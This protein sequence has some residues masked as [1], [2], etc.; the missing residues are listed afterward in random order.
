MAKRSP[1]KVLLFLILLLVVAYLCKRGW[2][3]FYATSLPSDMPP[4]M[5]S[6]V[7][8]GDY[9]YVHNT[10]PGAVSQPG[11]F[12]MGDESRA[13]VANTPTPS[14]AQ[15]KAAPQDDKT[16]ISMFQ[17]DWGV[18]S[19]S[20][21]WY[22]YNGRTVYGRYVGVN[23]W[24]SISYVVKPPPPPAAPAPVSTGVYCIGEVGS[25]GDAWATRHYAG[26]HWIR[27]APPVGNGVYWIWGVSNSGNEARP[28]NEAF[29]F[30]HS[31]NNTTGSNIQA[32]MYGGADNYAT[33][34]I[35]GEQL[36]RFDGSL[37]SPYENVTLRPGANNIQIF[38]QNGSASPAAVWL[39][40]KD[41][42]GRILVKSDCTNWSTSP[43]AAAAPAA[44]CPDMSQYM[45]KSS[46]NSCAAPNSCVDMT[47]YKSNSNSAPLLSSLP[48]PSIAHNVNLPHY[49]Q[50]LVD[51]QVSIDSR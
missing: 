50:R 35:N 23:H 3:G 38:G 34:T 22:T 11:S 5:G 13:W 14:E 16:L 24:W 4:D 33:V 32:Q 26:G 29:T 21:G 39:M 43:P 25:G 51:D 9:I 31:Y 49:C 47:H 44:A 10:S 37:S 15:L 46:C 12:D 20:R 17:W 30:Y 8:V 18:G 42:S 2:E 19:R 40:I 41:T 6:P 7:R 45:P 36:P 1:L 48:T 28:D 27:N